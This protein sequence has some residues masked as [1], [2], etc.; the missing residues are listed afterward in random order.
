MYSSFQIYYLSVPLKATDALERWYRQ[1]IQVGKIDNNIVCFIL[2]K[3]Y[4]TK[5]CFK[6]NLKGP[7]YFSTE[8]RFPFNQCIL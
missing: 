7:E 8:A 5:T 2:F 3:Y 1:S 4:Y 6:R